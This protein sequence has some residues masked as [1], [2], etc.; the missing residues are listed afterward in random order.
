MEPA[1]AAQL[2]PMLEQLASEKNIPTLVSPAVNFSPDTW[3][4]I[5]WL[6]E[7]F[8]NC[9]GC[10]VDAIAMHSYTCDASFLDQHIR[11]YYE[12][13]LPIWLTEFACEDDP[14]KTN[15]NGQATYMQDA[16]Q[17]LENN[18]FVE[19]YAWYSKDVPGNDETSASASLVTEAGLTSLGE[20]YKALPSVS[21]KTVLDP[22]ARTRDNIFEKK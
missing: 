5:E 15:A 16:V 9:P 17:Y 19:K 6:R 13:R 20:L 12:F 21:S 14:S 8:S 22:A 4:P 2:W 1:A 7:F 11:L 18:P 3:G 10:R